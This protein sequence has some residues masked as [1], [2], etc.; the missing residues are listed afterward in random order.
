MIAEKKHAKY[1]ASGAHRWLN[2]AASVSLSEKMPKPPDS[3]YA[4][5]GTDA[6]AIL[7]AILKM[8][9]IV[10]YDS[11]QFMFAKSAAEE[12]I[13]LQNKVNGEL[14]VETKVD[15]SFVHK[16]AFGTLDAAVLEH[17]GR[18]YVIDYKYGAGY[19]VEVKDNPQLIF[20]ALGLAHQYDYNFE[21]VELMVI[22]PRASHKD[23][24]IRRHRMTMYELLTWADDFLHAI[25]AAE[26]KNPKATPGDWCKWCPAAPICPAI[27]SKAMAQ[28]Q[29]DFADV[30]LELLPKS[31]EAMWTGEQLGETLSAM[32]KL[33]TWITE[34]RRYA[35]DK[36]SRGDKISGWKLV[37]KRAQRVWADPELTSRRAVRK[38][39]VSV[40]DTTLFSPAKFEKQI[41][42]SKK[43]LEEHTTKVSSGLTMVRDKDERET[44]N[45]LELDFKNDYI[46]T[47]P[48]KKRGKHGK[49]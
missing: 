1:S 42:G 35:F 32:Q 34:V 37:P 25:E 26:S 5:E 40:F 19:A 27:S 7:E 39:G 24:S 41:K 4:K 12:I 44:A 46:E 33:E 28:A 29:I 43:F 10:K 22:Q 38:F 18:L 23:G 36:L 49:K 20:Y 30:K 45:W 14:L 3:K 13:R 48:K 31:K 2:C 8:K 11:T 21:D 9:A 47:K 17:F 15:L 6:H 16:E